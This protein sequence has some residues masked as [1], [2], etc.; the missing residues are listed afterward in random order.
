MIQFVKICNNIK[1]KQSFLSFFKITGTNNYLLKNNLT[2]NLTI[3]QEH[4]Y[5]PDTN[6]GYLVNQ[7][8][9]RNTK[10][11][12]YSSETRTEGNILYLFIIRIGKY[13]NVNFC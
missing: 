10:R 5:D 3:S 4:F 11:K 12:R 7:L 6:T 9:F 8:K 1:P 2:Y 13:I